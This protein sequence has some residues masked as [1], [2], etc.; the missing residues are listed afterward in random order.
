MAKKEHR[1]VKSPKKGDQAS[2]SIGLSLAIAQRG[3]TNLTEC[4]QFTM[5]VA[6]DVR[7]GIVRSADAQ[8][9]ATNVGKTLKATEMQ[10]KYGNE[11]PMRLAGPPTA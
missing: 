9:I 5:A 3:V 7:C 10:I 4:A 1:V 6:T 8:A 11:K 2:K